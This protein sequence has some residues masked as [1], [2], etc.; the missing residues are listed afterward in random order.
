MFDP[1][2]NIGSIATIVV[3]IVGGVGFVW[4]SRATSMVLATRLEARDEND[5]QWRLTVD[6]RFEVLERNTEALNNL[7]LANKERDGRLNLFEERMMAQGKR[8]DE[9]RS[10]QG[11][12]EG[13]RFDQLCDRFN[14]LITT[15][16]KS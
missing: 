16:E 14:Q 6:R 12:L 8:L 9:V 3:M 1:T 10:T 2:I 11:R 4:H 15:M 7:A 13:G 5:R